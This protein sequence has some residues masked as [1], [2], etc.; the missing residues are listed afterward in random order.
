MRRVAGVVLGFLLALAAGPLWADQGPYPETEA[1]RNAAFDA[2]IWQ[3]EAKSYP[4]EGAHASLDLKPGLSL[5]L[6]S[7]AQ[8][9]EWLINGVEF[10]DTVAALTYSNGSAKALAFVQWHDEGYV[11]DTQWNDVDSDKLLEQY[12]DAT[13]RSNKDRV[14]N[15]RNALHVIG[16]LQKPEYDQA[17]HTV[18]FALELSNGKANSANVK[19]LHLGREGYA[20]ITWAGSMSVFQNS[21]N[22]PALLSTVLASYK[23]DQGHSYDD[24]KQGDKVAAYGIAGLVATALGVKF[25]K[26]LLAALLAFLIAG[27]KIAIPAV[28]VFGAGIVKFWRRLFGRRADS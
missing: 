6:G 10:P 3:H 16:W 8:R 22:P 7:D 24:F 19:A 17:T 23:F 1:E 5:L 4:L 2:L 18:S 20:S 9:L 25:G 21:G 13:E 15:G 28:A 26:G 14:A 12:R 11:T 27:K